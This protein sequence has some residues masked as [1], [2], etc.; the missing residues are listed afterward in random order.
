MTQCSNINHHTLPHITRVLLCFKKYKE[1][2]QIAAAGGKEER[3]KDVKSQ[4]ACV[5]NGRH[6][7]THRVQQVKQ[8]T[9]CC[10]QGVTRGNLMYVQEKKH[11]RL[12]L[13]IFFSLSTR[14]DGSEILQRT[15]KDDGVHV[16]NAVSSMI[17]KLCFSRCGLKEAAISF[18]KARRL[19]VAPMYTR[20]ATRCAQKL[21]HAVL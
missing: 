8:L 9:D 1:C 10:V 18:L 5:P 7:N 4:I 17:M 20:A 13:G 12:L 6:S 14:M 15:F 2:V 3:E 16:L 21:Q 11:E 19:L